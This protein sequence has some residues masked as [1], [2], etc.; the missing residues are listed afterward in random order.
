MKVNFIE[1]NP[2]PVKT[3]LSM[4]GYLQENFRLPLV[5]IEDKNRPVVEKCLKELGLI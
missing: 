4:M 5:P 1:S 2:I 3:A